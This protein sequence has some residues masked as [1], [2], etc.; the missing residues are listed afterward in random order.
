MI[1]SLTAFFSLAI[2]LSAV[3]LGQDSDSVAVSH[4]AKIPP[5]RASA[6]AGCAADRRTDPNAGI[7]V[8]EVILEGATVSSSELS[9]ITSGVEGVCFDEQSEVVGEAIRDAFSDQG[10]AQVDVENVTLKASDTLSIPKPVTVRAE[11]TEGPRFRFGTIRFIGNHAFSDAK[12]RAVFPIKKGQLFQRSKIASGFDEIR[13]LYVPAGYED[14]MFVP[15]IVFSSAGTVELQLTISEGP[16][17]HMG[18]LKIY[19]KKE[20]ADRLGSEWN[21]RAGAVFDGSYPQSFLDESHSLPRD[22]SGQDIVLVRN[23]PE[24]S[25]AVLLVVDQTDPGLQSAPKEV[26]CKKTDRGKESD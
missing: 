5:Q 16:Q 14:L 17:Y 21:L 6:S 26:R 23:C 9:T 25:I 13:K 7:L 15:D 10:F 1:R 8:S 2:L 22:F 19:A 11:I 20:I 18:E 3:A 24:S 12:L 4:A